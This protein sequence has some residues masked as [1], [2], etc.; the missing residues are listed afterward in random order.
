MILSEGRDKGEVAGNGALHEHLGPDA[1][2]KGTGSP[3]ELPEPFTS[4]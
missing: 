3:D 4:L 1:L 2:S